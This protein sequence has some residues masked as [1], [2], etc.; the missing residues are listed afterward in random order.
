MSIDYL[1]TEHA[2]IYSFQETALE[3]H[4]NTRGLNFQRSSE[5]PGSKSCCP[6]FLSSLSFYRVRRR[7][8]WGGIN[9]INV[10]KLSCFFYFFCLVE[11]KICWALAQTNFFSYQVASASHETSCRR[12]EESN[13]RPPASTLAYIYIDSK[14]ES[15]GF[16][17]FF[18]ACLLSL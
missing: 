16:S 3:S 14:Q 8:H 5:G 15:C 9:T 13:P 2:Y 6:S 1:I 10:K 4:V 11:L 17:F 18:L 12:R 7:D